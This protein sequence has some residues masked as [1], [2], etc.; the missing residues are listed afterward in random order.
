MYIKDGYT[1]ELDTI[2]D[3]LLQICSDD[4]LDT[5]LQLAAIEGL[6]EIGHPRAVEELKNLSASEHLS[7][8]LRKAAT[9]ALGKSVGLFITNH[10]FEEN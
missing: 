3:Y 5:G 4:D 8:E 7:A 9:I 10:S 6:G 2:I 1:L